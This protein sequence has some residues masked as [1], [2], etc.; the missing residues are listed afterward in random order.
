MQAFNTVSLISPNR[1]HNYWL[2]YNEHR[3]DAMALNAEERRGKLRK[4]TGS[5]K[6][7]M[8]RRF[9]NGETRR[10]SCPVIHE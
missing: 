3:V 2:R 4:A 8:I 10:E 5:R 6:Q 9:L 1:F 7:A